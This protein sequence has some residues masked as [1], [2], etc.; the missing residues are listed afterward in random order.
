M[1]LAFTHHIDHCAARLVDYLI[2]LDRDRSPARGGGV[3]LDKGG[4]QVFVGGVTISL[5]FMLNE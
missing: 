2:R 3:A 5:A 1:L 4:R